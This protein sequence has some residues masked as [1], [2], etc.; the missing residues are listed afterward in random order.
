MDD[1]L[2]PARLDTL[3]D[4][5]DPDASATRFATEISHSTSDEATAELQTQLAR[6]LGLAGRGEEA[7]A[8]L[9]SIETLSPL[10][11]IRLSLERG[12]RL[13]SDGFAEQAV[14]YFADALA[15]A[16]EHRDDFLA[17][18]AVHMLAIADVENSLGWAVRG[19][20]F[21]AA[22]P[23]LRT[24]R[25]AIALHNNLGW[26]LFDADRF[27]EALTEFHLSLDAA[28]AYG[29]P[30]QQE[31]AEEAIAETRAAITALQQ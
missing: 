6:A 1:R 14:A 4:F 30:Q 5:S 31:W 29:T 15:L 28:K 17:A 8:L 9:E 16:E 24:K 2:D 20:G 18:D 12:R 23:D 13:N 27:E 3:W 21:V 26:Q 19:I 10:V 25:W 7:D 11:A 22:S